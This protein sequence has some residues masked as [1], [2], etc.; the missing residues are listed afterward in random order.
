M[1]EP[2]E[3]S[4]GEVLDRDATRRQQANVSAT[5]YFLK[6]WAQTHSVFQEGGAPNEADWL[7]SWQRPLRKNIGNVYCAGFVN[8]CGARD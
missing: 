2:T 6:R 3:P 1:N 8:R 5:Y 4:R 7:R